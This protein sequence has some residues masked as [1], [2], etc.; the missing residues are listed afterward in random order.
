M[1]F[2]ALFNHKCDL[3]FDAYNLIIKIKSTLLSKIELC[4]KKIVKQMTKV[5]CKKQAVISYEN[6]ATK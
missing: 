5:G 1:I 6:F 2:S 3:H 4:D